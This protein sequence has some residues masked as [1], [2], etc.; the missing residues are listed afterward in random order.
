MARIHVGGLG[1]WF[2]LG[3]HQPAFTPATPFGGRARP[4][5]PF[6]GRARPAKPQVPARPDLGPRLRSERPVPD[7]RQGRS[8]VAVGVGW[9]VQKPSWTAAACSYR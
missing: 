5:K 1:W 2:D 4:A 9:A 6:G 8:Q 7:V 3:S